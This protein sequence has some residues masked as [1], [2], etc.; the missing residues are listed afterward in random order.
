MIL[1][2]D[3]ALLPRRH[4]VYLRRLGKTGLAVIYSSGNYKVAA[5]VMS[6]VIGTRW[7]KQ[8]TEVERRELSRWDGLRKSRESKEE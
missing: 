3:N 5:E 7:M 2:A 1:P 6:D 8:R 4:S